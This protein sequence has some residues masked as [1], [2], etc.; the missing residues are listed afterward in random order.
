MFLSR[1][2]HS[3]AR[4]STMYSATVL[5]L[6]LSLVAGSA[7]AQEVAGPGASHSATNEQF[8]A[9]CNDITGECED[10]VS[11]LDCPASSRFVPD[12][13][14]CD[15]DPP[16]GQAFTGACCDELTGECENNVFH[17]HC[18]APH[19][20]WVAGLGCAD[21]VPSCGAAV[22]GTFRQLDVD[23]AG[24]FTPRSAWGAL[25][26]L[27][28]GFPETVRYFN[29]NV[30]DRWVIQNMPVLSEQGAGVVHE[31]RFCFD[32]GVPDGTPVYS[33]DYGLA[34]TPD[35][36]DAPPPM[37][38]AAPVIST[39]IVAHSGAL[40]FPI[41]P[42][43]PPDP[44]RLGGIVLDAPAT[45]AGFP[46]QECGPG[47]CAPAALSNSLQWLNDQHNLDMPTSLITIDAMKTAS[48][49]DPNARVVSY[50][51]EGDDL[52]FW[53]LKAEYCADLGLPIT[54]RV[55]AN[56]GAVKDALEDGQDVELCGHHHVAAVTGL[57]ALPDG[58]I[59]LKVAHDTRQ[60]ADG[61][62]T[63]E[64]IIYDVAN[65]IFV[66]GS[67]GFFHG[68]S[69]HYFVIE[70]P[71]ESPPAWYG[72]DDGLTITREHPLDDYTWPPTESGGYPLP[73]WTG[74]AMWEQSGVQHFDDGIGLLGPSR[75]GYFEFLMENEYLEFFTN[76]VWVRFQSRTQDGSCSIA[77]AVP[78]NCVEL[79]VMIETIPYS[80]EWDLTTMTYEIDPQPAWER[81]RWN[82]STETI[83]W[84]TVRVRDLQFATHCKPVDDTTCGYTYAFATEECYLPDFQHGGESYWMGFGS[85]PPP[86][87]PP[88]EPFY[89]HDEFNGR[90]GVLTACTNDGAVAWGWFDVVADS[91]RATEVWLDYDVYGQVTDEMTLTTGPGES[92]ILSGRQTAE[93]LGDGW[94]HYVQTAIVQPAP[95]AMEVV[96]DG[97]VSF[98]QLRFA[99]RNIDAPYPK[100]DLNCDA[101]ISAADIDPFVV[102]LTGGS[103]LYY[104]SWPDCVYLNA[105][106]NLDNVVS[107]ADID[108]FVA[109]LVGK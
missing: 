64:T 29:L 26:F 51:D 58:N 68:Q 101:V 7:T 39:M 88:V 86:P 48:N 54:T 21:L 104:Q 82:L 97:C 103:D 12:E 53:K 24:E 9:C 81:V 59:A 16:C 74:G 83:S 66:G 47:E 84:A 50:Y 40:G 6:T 5:L 78:D 41:P 13:S 62:T 8:G 106:C 32:L 34:L 27:Y 108:A 30:D 90:Q 79:D 93:S 57:A 46:N 71:L 19:L 36:L 1:F 72:A 31:E 25:D 96:F 55:I 60:G 15:L 43:P 107:A 76:E 69:F 44:V 100:G 89:W 70:C 20:R 22:P 102:A 52:A 98:D 37:V 10:N 109:I 85:I 95:S 28:L 11:S 61:G 2:A 67:P 33:I 65:D 94:W 75:V 73:P 23:L 63:Y 87:L 17:Y 91:E 77:T 92:V 80:T 35:V 14:C 4:D 49:W 18:D 56:F 38:S 42:L 3:A 99:A 105:D 45:H